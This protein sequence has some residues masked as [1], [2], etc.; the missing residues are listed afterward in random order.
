M[1][2]ERIPEIFFPPLLY[3]ENIGLMLAPQDFMRLSLSCFG[4]EFQ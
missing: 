3:R 1:I 4:F 2:E